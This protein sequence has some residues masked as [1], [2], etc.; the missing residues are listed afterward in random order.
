MDAYKHES[1]EKNIIHYCKLMN[2]SYH[3]IL[4]RE[5]NYHKIDTSVSEEEAQHKVCDI[6]DNIINYKKYKELATKLNIN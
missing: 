3:D 4:P 6:L 1:Q 5:E 2:R